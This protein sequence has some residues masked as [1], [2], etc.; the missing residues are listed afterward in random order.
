VTSDLP[1]PENQSHEVDD[2]LARRAI[3]LIDLTDL[4]D[5]HSVA[6]IDDLC[7]RAKTHGTAAICVWPEHVARCVAK[8]S[9]SGVRVATVVNFPNGEEP[10]GEVLASTQAALDAGADDIDVV[11]PYRAFLDGDLEYAGQ[12][13]SQV[14]A[15]IAP[16]NLL[17]VVLESGELGDADVVAAAATLAIENGAD[18]VKTSTGK[19]P[20]GASISA[21][22]A[23]IGAIA[24]ARGQGRS[25]GLKPSGGIRSYADAASY[26][27]VAESV[28]GSGWATPAT[29]RFGANG[30][31]DALLEVLDGS[32]PSSNTDPNG[33]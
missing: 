31:L 7:A 3:T 28:M 15:L 13:V 2:A 16:P 19:V 18:F 27:D 23:M 5:D 22:T 1:R 9:G 6:G 8:L 25:I 29:F 17:K 12:V 11:L 24:E 33:Y 30:L 10:I 20:A 32:E 4:A 21:A 26:I 14:A